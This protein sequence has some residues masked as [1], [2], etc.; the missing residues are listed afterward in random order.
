MVA[1]AG[2]DFESLDELEGSSL[3]L[4]EFSWALTKGCAERISNAALFYLKLYH[5]SKKLIELASN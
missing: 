3:M 2:I 1:L 4:V 5:L